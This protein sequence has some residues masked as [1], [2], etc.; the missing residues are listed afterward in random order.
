MSDN[1]SIGFFGA[2]WRFVSFYKIRKALGIARAADRQFT[3]SAAGISDAFDIEHDSLVRDYKELLN[4]VSG[5]E[6]AVQMKRDQK[7]AIAKNLEQAQAA[8][9]GAVRKY[10][11]EAA[12]GDAADKAVLAKHKT[13]GVTF[14]ADVERLTAQMNALDKE[15][16]EGEPALVQLETRLTAMQKRIRELPAEK[17]QKIAKF[18][19]NKAIIDANE[20]LANLKT[21]SE[22]SPIDAVNKALDEQAA[23]AKVSSRISGT[24]SD[25]VRDEYVNA[26]A[27]STASDGF[28]ALVAAQ[29]AKKADKTG[30]PQAVTS[31]REKI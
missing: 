13:N 11:E 8:L 18:V 6:T 26:G 29:A 7:G 19:S 28:D 23:K 30:A 17:A 3:G 24:D 9:T 15:I 16:A 27:A 5:V 10:S 31:E 12:K 20:K 4:A 1:N 22:R 14:Q 2:V 21:S 25:S